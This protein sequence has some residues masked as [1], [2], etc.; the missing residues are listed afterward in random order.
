MED[1]YNAEDSNDSETRRLIIARL[2]NFR[3]RSIS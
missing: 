1:Q 2:A 3:P